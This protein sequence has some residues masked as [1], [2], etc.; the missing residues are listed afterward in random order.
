MDKKKRRRK[1]NNLLKQQRSKGN[2]Q[3]LEERVISFLSGMDKP[4]STTMILHGIG[5]PDY[6]RKSLKTILRELV[7]N[8]KITRKNKKFVVPDHKNLIEAIMA[9]TSRGFG[10]ASLDGKMN[11]GKDIFI[12]QGNLGGASHGDTVLV[13]VMDSGSRGRSEGIVILVKKRAVKT[14]C[15]IYSGGKRDGYVLPDNPKLPFK[16][17]IEEGKSKN[18][19]SGL[20]VIARIDDYR[21]ENQDPSGEIIEILGDPLTAPVQI[22]MAIEQLSLPLEFPAKVLE[23]TENLSPQTECKQ[24][25]RDLRDIEHVTIDGATARDFDDAVCVEKTKNGYRLFVSIADVSHYVQPGSAIDQEAYKRG[26]SVYFPNMV[27]PML[28]ERLSN[29]LCSLVPDQDRPAFTA[30]LDFDR[31]GQQVRAEYCRSMIRSRQRFT[32]DTVHE[33]LYLKDKPTENEQNSLLPMLILAEQLSNLLRK[34]REQRGS[35]GFT[36][37]EAA[38]TIKN[39]NISSISHIKRNDAH[40]LIEDFMLAAN[41]AVAETLALADQDVL[42]RVHEKP[43]PEKVKTFTDAASAMGLV[44]PK[45]EITPT[46]FAEVLDK[47]RDKPTQYVINNLLLRTMQQARYSPDNLIHFGLAANYYLHFTSPIRRYP[48]LI[49][50]RVISNFLTRK[51][52]QEKIMPVISGKKNLSEAAIH[53]SRKERRAIEGERDVRAR[54]S[55]IFLVD[56]IGEEFNAV[57]SGVSGFGL[58]IELIDSF[59]SGLIPIGDIKDDYYVIDSRAHRLVGERTNNIFQMGNQ[60]RV[61]IERVDLASKRILF[62]IVDKVI[63]EQSA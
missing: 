32:Y 42:F 58:Y 50:H 28:P 52:G 25:R 40:L 6:I 36:I 57:I 3:P 19:D 49:V 4:A 5:L 14:L 8:G 20:A 30:I 13:R 45:T 34:K 62:S 56:K 44:L 54:L 21:D 27:L 55:C 63:D 51:S 22:R 39:D 18:S 12:K 33:I 2:Q 60:I 23:E 59:I 9:I 17:F 26:T 53:L 11:K 38:I 48:D 31:Q 16:V 15:G 1:P 41:E 37:P 47:V 46:W 29:D 61:I 10:F 7:K 35:L 43:D 24:D